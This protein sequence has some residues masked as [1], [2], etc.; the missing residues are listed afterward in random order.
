MRSAALLITLLA[1]SLGLAGCGGGEETGALPETVEGTLPEVTTTEE[2]QE[3][4]KVQGVAANGAAVYTSAGCGGCHALEAAGSSGSIG[5]DLD[6]AQPDFA[7]AFTTIKNGR[8]VM[9]SFEGEL[10]EQQI[11]DVAQYVVESTQG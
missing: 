5:P 8:G 2:E 4:P 3:A 9:P 11:A 10:E 1:L 7:Y 6:D